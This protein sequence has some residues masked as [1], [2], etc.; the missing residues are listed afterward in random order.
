MKRGEIRRIQ[1]WDGT[2]IWV[3]NRDGFYHPFESHL[4][5]LLGIDSPS[6]IYK[7]TNMELKQAFETQFLTH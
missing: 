3:E 7:Y 4:K 2:Y 5:S 1:K 6:L